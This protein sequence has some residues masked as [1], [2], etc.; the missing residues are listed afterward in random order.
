M[1]QIWDPPPHQCHL[2]SSQS[3]CWGCTGTISGTQQQLGASKKP[4]VLSLYWEGFPGSEKVPRT[5]MGK[6]KVTLILRPPGTLGSKAGQPGC[7][8]TD[9]D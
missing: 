7:S 3:I 8:G 9:L 5:T 6:N 1:L 2:Y 4:P